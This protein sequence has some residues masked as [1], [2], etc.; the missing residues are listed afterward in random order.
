MTEAELRAFMQGVVV[1]NEGKIIIS[2]TSVGTKIANIDY[3]E[4]GSAIVTYTDGSVINIDKVKTDDYGKITRIYMSAN[5][6]TKYINCTYDNDYLRAVGDISVDDVE[7]LGINTSFNLQDKTVKASTKEDITVTYDEN[8]DGLGTVTVTKADIL[9]QEKTVTPTAESQTVTNDTDYD[10]LSSVVVNGD[11]NLIPENIKKDISIFGI[12]GTLTGSSGGTG[13]DMTVEKLWGGATGSATTL[14]L[15]KSA[16]D[17]DII[18]VCGTSETGNTNG[19]DTAMFLTETIKNAS[20]LTVAW[21]AYDTRYA[22]LNFSED[23]NSIN[24]S[25]SNQYISDVY[26]VK[27]GS[28]HTYSTEEQIVGTWIDGKPIY[29]KTVS[30][31]AGSNDAGLISDVDTFVNVNGYVIYADG[32]TRQIAS[33]NYSQCFVF[34]ETDSTSV[35]IHGSNRTGGYVTIQYTKTTD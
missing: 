20:N 8:Y 9:L 13:E 24:C 31:P 32:Y 21:Y 7:S 29:E 34:K 2:K 28:N 14:E 22:A 19:G 5:G 27:F 4:K 10:G 25:Y 16:F 23:G 26:G 30:I 33:N 11:S 15:S 35:F 18:V 12:L 17:Y 3:G 1:S 6:E